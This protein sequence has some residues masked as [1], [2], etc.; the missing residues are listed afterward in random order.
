ML[1]IQLKKFEYKFLDST[2]EFMSHF[3]TLTTVLWLRNFSYSWG[4]NIKLF[5]CKGAQYVQITFKKSQKKM[6]QT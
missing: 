4:I 3:L 5:R 6:F 1:L 2:V